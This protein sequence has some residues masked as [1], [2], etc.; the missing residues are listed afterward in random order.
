MKILWIVLLILIINPIYAVDSWVEDKEVYFITNNATYNFNYTHTFK[1]HIYIN[2][3]ILEIDNKIYDIKSSE[4]VNVTLLELPNSKLKFKSI[5]A[6]YITSGS[7]EFNLSSYLNRLAILFI[8]QSYI[9]YYK[10]SDNSII[11]SYS[12]SGLYQFYSLFPNL[13]RLYFYN[14]KIEIL[15]SKNRVISSKNMHLID[16]SIYYYNSYN[17]K[18]IDKELINSSRNYYFIYK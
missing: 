6:F 2:E 5:E 8:N 10:I 9:D 4:K 14:N 15:S 17:R 13:G 18:E 7:H 11:L 12:S 1:D 3:H 16:R